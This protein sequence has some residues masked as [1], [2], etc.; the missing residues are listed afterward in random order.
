MQRKIKAFCFDLFD[1]LADAHRHLV[2]TESDAAGVPREVWDAAMWEEKLCFDRGI[3]NIKTIRE[4]IDRACDALPVPVPEER[5]TA[6][7]EARRERLRLAVTEI[8]PRIVSTIRELKARGYKIG[9]VSNADVCDEA[10][11]PE[12]P[13]F[14]CFDDSIFS[15]DVGLLKPDAAIY[16]LSLEHLGVLPE[17]AVFVGDGGSEELAGA[18]AAGLRTVCTEYLKKYDGER[19]AR[20]HQSADHVIEQFEELLALTF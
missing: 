11:W 17:E 13:V 5:R 7:M 2:Q 19:R 9:L 20:I 18:K 10:C 3:G 4:M 8:D 6:A 1:T 12:S 15:C 16:R 14:S